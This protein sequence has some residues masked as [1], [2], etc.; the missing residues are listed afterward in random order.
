MNC[1]NTRAIVDFFMLKYSTSMTKSYGGPD[2]PSY[3]LEL[4][5]NH[6]EGFEVPTHIHGSLQ[7]ALTIALKECQRERDKS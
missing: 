1:R 2:L 3:K 6:P 7:E 4:L 5:S